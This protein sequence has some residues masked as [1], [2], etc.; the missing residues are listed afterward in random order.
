[1]PLT[2]GVKGRCNNREG[3]HPFISWRLLRRS[4]FQTKAGKIQTKVY[5]F[6]AKQK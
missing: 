5:T 4:F 2:P 3:Y 1:M 6:N